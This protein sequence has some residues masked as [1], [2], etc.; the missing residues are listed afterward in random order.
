MG[1][2]RGKV[3]DPLRSATCAHVARDAVGRADG[4]EGGRVRRRETARRTPVR[5]E[6]APGPDGS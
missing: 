3:H 2:E 5:H 4:R 1:S 6:S